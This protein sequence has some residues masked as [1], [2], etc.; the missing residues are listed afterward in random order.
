MASIENRMLPRMVRRE[1][2]KDYFKEI[3][4]LSARLENRKTTTDRLVM[5]AKR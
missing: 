2:K 1:G 4:S 3:S 5:E